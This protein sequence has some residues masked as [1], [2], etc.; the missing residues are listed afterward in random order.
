MC[1][2]HGK[3]CELLIRRNKLLKEEVGEMRQQRINKEK[4][5]FEVKSR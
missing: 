1:Y 4:D 5:V 3:E 2:V